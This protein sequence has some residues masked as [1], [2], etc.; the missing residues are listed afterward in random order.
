MKK[1]TNKK[2]NKKYS[3]VNEKKTNIKCKGS[4]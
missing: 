3:Y 2:K 4:Q 1:E